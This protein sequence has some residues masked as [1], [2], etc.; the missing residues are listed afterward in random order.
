MALSRDIVDTPLW[1]FNV[2]SPLY[3]EHFCIVSMYTG[4][5]LCMPV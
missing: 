2:A 1:R 3:D 5:F 4:V